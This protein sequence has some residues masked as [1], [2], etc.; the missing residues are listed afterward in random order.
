MNI[1][2]QV[3]HQHDMT[4]RVLYDWAQLF[5]LSFS[6]EQEFAVLPSTIMITILNYPLF[7]RETDR[8]HTVFHLREDE[9]HFLWSPHLE[10]H[11]IHLSKFMV[12]WKKYRREMD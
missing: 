8:S 12:K 11:A 3:T 6:K 10:F 5:S 7:S 4:E 2:V 9:E 1:E